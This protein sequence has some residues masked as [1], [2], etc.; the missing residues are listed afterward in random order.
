MYLQWGYVGYPINFTVQYRLADTSPWTSAT[1]LSSSTYYPTGWEAGQRYEWRVRTDCANGNSTAFSPSRFITVPCNAPTYLNVSGLT[2]STAQLSWGYYTNTTPYELQWRLQQP[3]NS[4]YS[5]ATIITNSYSLTGLTAGAGY[6]YRVRTVCSASATSAFTAPYSFT[7][8]CGA[9]NYQSAYNITST[10]AVLQWSS[11][12]Y[13]S[14]Y[15]L[16]YRVVGGPVSTT[17]SALTGTTFSVTG[18]SNSTAYEFLVQ[19]ICPDG[20]LSVFS[21]PF[22]FTTQC[23]IPPNVY[24]YAG[25]N[26]ANLDWSSYGSDTRYE[27]VY[28]VVGSPVSTTVTS[29]SSSGS[30]V[31]YALT[32]LTTNTAYEWQVRTVCADG[33]RSAFTA[34]QPF[35]TTACQ[36]PYAA[37]ESYVISTVARVTWY[38]ITGF[39]Y[40]VRWRLAGASVWSASATVPASATASNTFYLIAGLTSNTAYEWQVGTLCP[41][42]TQSGFTAIRSF[43]TNCPVT[44]TTSVYNISPTDASVYWSAN[45]ALNYTVRWRPANSVT[46]PWNE[47]GTLATGVYYYSLTGLTSGT[48]YE[49]QV[50]TVCGSGIVGYANSVTF[51]AQCQP[52][53]SLYAFPITDRTALLNFSGY[54]V[55]PGIRYDVQYQPQGS[56]GSPTMVSGIGSITLLLTSLSAVTAYTWQVRTICTDGTYSAFST[57]QSFT[58]RTACPAMYTIRD[59]YWSD[60]SIWSCGFVPSSA[61]DVEI[62]HSVTV[63]S[64]S[65]NQARKVGYAVGGK[66][67]YLPGGKLQLGQ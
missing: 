46:T 3:I 22:S 64:Y 41:D 7:P 34:P 19:V 63:S 57:L 9:V 28:R 15:N 12:N 65:A 20:S 33:N 52:P 54:S 44:T 39:Q 1:G 55:L 62:R 17:V 48:T 16:V 8:Q 31:Y 14:T 38:S 51:V 6:E 53:A 11:P 40:T 10:G 25:S 32:G 29:L 37:Y 13:T 18:L 43:T 26:S 42:G 36:V 50:G 56:T 45:S 47:S 23:T 24:G 58:T 27:L 21:T 4:P 2:G 67:V 35:T 49:V 59:G 60:Y 66:L 61:H 30:Y 5:S